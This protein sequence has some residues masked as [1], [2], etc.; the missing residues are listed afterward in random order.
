M[1]RRIDLM[2]G[3]GRSP[4]FIRALL[5]SGALLSSI[6]LLAALGLVTGAFPLIGLA[7]AGVILIIGTSFVNLAALPVL[8]FAVI[9]IVQRVGGD[10]GILSLSDLMLF[11]A[12]FPAILLL[13]PSRTDV[14]LRRILWMSLI[15]QAA[16]LFTVIANPYTSN[17]VEWV[18]ELLLVSGAIVV[19]YAAG[20]SGNGR[21]ALKLLMISCLV[22]AGLTLLTGVT[23]IAGGN[24]GPVYVEWP[25]YMHKNYIGCVLAFAA[26]VAYAQPDI[27]G[28]RKSGFSAFFLIMLLGVLAAQSKQALVSII[29]GVLVIILR[30]IPG[31]DGQPPRKRSKAI[32]L[33]LV[34]VAIFV[35]SVTKGQ[36]T[37]DNQFNAANQRLTW[38]SDAWQI[39]SSSPWFGVGLRYWYTG[40]YPAFQPPNAEF[41]MLASAGIVGLAG[42]LIMFAGIL[43][44]LWKLPAAVGTLPFALVLMRFAQGQL[45]LF[46]V[47]VQVSVP[48][49]VA[50]LL[51][52]HSQWQQSQAEAAGEQVTPAPTH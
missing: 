35:Y 16:L 24:W 32:L 28:W 33:P 25:Y 9:I 51:M 52:G 3:R 11:G 21:L 29:V 46:W 26:V 1:V 14:H 8:S 41:E 17:A 23:Q 6:G 7:A 43:W 42:F 20:I 5:A 34:P 18:H 49:A 37:S 30:P 13:L 38:Y 39:F 27:L 40:N 47:A 2:T 36:L 50:G 44:T 4:E 15:Y 10:S 22:I 48:F 19:G 12:A 31:S 45:D